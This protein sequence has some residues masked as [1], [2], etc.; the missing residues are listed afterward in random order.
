MTFSAYQARHNEMH[1]SIEGR[2]DASG[3]LG[4][5]NPNEAKPVLTADT[6][7]ELEQEA[8]AHLGK[9]PDAFLYL[10]D[11]GRRV[12][13]IMI[14]EKHHAA[15]GRA[16]RRTAVS[17]AILV[18]SFTCLIGASLAPLGTLA[19]LGFVGTASLYFLILRW[20]L[21][22][23]IEGAVVCEILLIIVL[24]LTPLLQRLGSNAA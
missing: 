4:I 17:V 21:Y 12:H 20:D 8:R 18:F 14:N 6:L 1:F 9:E 22:N 2:D 23:E 19:L 3:I 24:L 7:E 16:N 10:T 11:G 15:I 5:F 13:R